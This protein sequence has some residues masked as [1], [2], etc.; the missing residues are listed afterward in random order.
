MRPLLFL[1]SALT[2]LAQNDPV[3][4]QFSPST[5]KGAL[6]R[7]ASGPAPRVA[8]I[9]THRT[10]NF[11]SHIATRELS[12]RGFL[13]LAMNPRFENNE[14]AV[15]WDEV[16]LDI[17]S[18]VEFLRK[19]PG[20]A[21]VILFGHSGGGT[22]MSFY[23]S[24]AEN[25][26]AICQGA[27]KLMPCSNVL[28][29]LPRADGV[30]FMDAHPGNSINGLRSIN[31]AILGNDPTRI[32]ATLDP[33]NPKNGFNPSGP[34]HYSSEFKERYFR[35][36]A[37]RTNR[38]IADAQ[39][40]MKQMQEGK[41]PYRDDDVFLITHGQGARL[42]S[43]DPSLRDRTAHPRKLLRNDGT[44]ATQI[45]ESAMHYG[46]PTRSAGSFRDTARLLTIRSFLSTNAI[47]ATHSQDAIDYCSTNNSVPCAVKSITVP[48]LF[49]AMGGYTFI[50]DNELHYELAASKDKDFIVVEGATHGATPCKE[51]ETTPGQ[52]GNSV[53][54]FFDYVAQWIQARYSR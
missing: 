15:N 35:A 10:A 41:Y 46:P 20:I 31:P 48:V 25:G 17:R 14:A 18:G 37:E 32:D 40:R 24:V 16:A 27:A 8:V 19:Q 23:Q 38:L 42:I 12:R 6:Y 7:P 44:I 11:L 2:C 53:K 45:V 54:N 22:S 1:V 50:R 30:V 4:V 26:P 43:F 52:Y 13:V 49:A 39:S 36:Q 21:K 3:F 51:C 28:A 33:F 5:T 29:G 47:R 34:S 9:L